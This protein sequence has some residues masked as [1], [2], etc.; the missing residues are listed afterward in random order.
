MTHL[1]APKL[2]K[3]HCFTCTFKRDDLRADIAYKHLVRLTLG[4]VS[5]TA[6]TKNGKR[7]K[8]TTFNNNILLL[9]H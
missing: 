4:S 6:L 5:A 8:L 2:S 7:R 1:T 3:R 9:S